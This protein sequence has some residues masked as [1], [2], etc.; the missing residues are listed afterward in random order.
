MF[1]AR[2]NIDFFSVAADIE[3][4]SGAGASRPQVR[5]KCG[6][7]QNQLNTV[8]NDQKI[9]RSGEVS[10]DSCL[11]KAQITGAVRRR[12]RARR[13]SRRQNRVFSGSG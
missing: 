6:L 10:A 11:R 2:K 5:R 8:L 9:G 3:A 1:C 4:V 12:R 7:R 13:R